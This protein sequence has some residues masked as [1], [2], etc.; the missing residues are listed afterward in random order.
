LHP[1]DLGFYY[2][3]K[4][5]P[6]GVQ[7]SGAFRAILTQLLQ[8][9]G[10][11]KE[12]IDIV[13]VI[14]NENQ[15]G[16]LY[17]TD[18][19]VLCALHLLTRRCGQV[20]LVFDGIDE[21][22]DQDTFF[23]R[24][25]E[26]SQISNSLTVGLF[27]RPTIKIPRSLG[28]DT[29]C[30]DL[31]N[32]QNHRDICTY[33]RPEIVD[34]V[35]YGMLPESTDI[36]DT[37]EKIS[38]RANGMFLWVTLLIRYLQ[39]PSLSTRQVSEA[40]SNLNRLQGLDSLYTAI[41]RALENQASVHAK[42]NTARAFQL[43]AF[44]YRPLR[45]SE[46]ECA[47]VIPL[48]RRVD[49]DDII[50]DFNQKLRRISGALMEIC[51]DARVRFIH[52][53]VLEYL[54]DPTQSY[55]DIKSTNVAS[56]AVLAHYSC[57]RFCLSYLYFT[58]P[59]E[60]LS[61]S[62]QTTADRDFQERRHPFLDYAS[63]FWSRHLLHGIKAVDL[64]SKDQEGDITDPIVHLASRFLT[65]K[66]A[67]TAW[68]EASWT[69]LHPPHI[70]LSFLDEELSETVTTF[71]PAETGKVD[72]LAQALQ[73]L[74]RL[75]LDLQDLDSSWAEVLRANPNEIW[76]PSI[77]AFIKSSFWVSVPGSKITRLALKETGENSICL[78]SQVSSDGLRLGVARLCLNTRY[79]SL[80]N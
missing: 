72:L 36:E 76:E 62:A 43:V 63:E 69:F 4:Q 59:A 6:E 24:L 68:I 57:A 66:A 18:R 14:W 21:C 45:A 46:L 5:S 38:N 48:D 27:S 51:D 39:S 10:N 32:S 79:I 26:L 53:S 23:D 16:Q 12:V 33:L 71:D 11:D 9:Y 17:A 15:V 29:L 3:D 44:S 70:D 30:L 35:E 42:V 47:M 75:S 74:Q 28:K 58:L 80:L 22:I 77:S 67:V 37:V 78:K 64:T 65:S 40:I 31:G 41:L 13:T 19:E 8:R 2:F 52:L 60:P 1:S 25:L 49:K 61:G 50:P 55:F 54:T 20:I 34:L 73:L 56:T 7:S